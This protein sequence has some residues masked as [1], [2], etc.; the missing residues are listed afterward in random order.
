MKQLDWHGTTVHYLK[1]DMF[2]PHCADTACK[3]EMFGSTCVPLWLHKA[4]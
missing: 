3:Q 4:I 2:L 1:F